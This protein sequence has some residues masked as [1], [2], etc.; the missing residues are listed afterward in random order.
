M[1]H[2]HRVCNAH[3]AFFHYIYT[4][5]A[6]KAT[7][8]FSDGGHN[9]TGEYWK[10]WYETDTFETDLQNLLAE[11]QPLYK[12]LHAY[13]LSKLMDTYPEDHFPQSGHI[14]SHVL[15]KNVN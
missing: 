9:D 2:V 4:I 12:S 7:H 5:N 11:L 8:V 3:S 14:P 15:G 13:V 1:T 10:S 6:Y